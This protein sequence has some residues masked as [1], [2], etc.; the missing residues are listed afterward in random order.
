MPFAVSA[1]HR[2]LG[3]N[4]AWTQSQFSAR[5]T[6]AA[7]TTLA[8]VKSSAK[9]GTKSPVKKAGAAASK[10]KA[11]A[12]TGAPPKKAVQNNQK[13]KL[14]RALSPFMVFLRETKARWFLPNTPSTEGMKRA[15]VAWKAMSDAEKVRACLSPS[16]V[17][18]SSPSPA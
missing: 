16:C 1:L 4:V 3:G 6:A 5:A 7:K 15:S 11:P 18:S 8:A 17:F 2:V 12:K 9:S 14:P 10:G 13:D